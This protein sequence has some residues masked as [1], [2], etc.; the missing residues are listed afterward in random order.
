MRIVY[1]EIR[2][3]RRLAAVRMDLSADTTLLVGANNSGKTSAM[4]ALR[5]FLIEQEQ[6]KFSL[7]DVPLA[8]WKSIDELGEAGDHDGA[9]ASSQW[10]SLLPSLDVWL[11]VSEDEIHHI[12]HLIPT[13][14]WSPDELI[15]VRLHLEPK[16]PK[17]LMESYRQA[18][19]AAAEALQGRPAQPGKF[20][21][22]PRSFTDFLKRRMASVVKVNA[23]LLDPNKQGGPKDG[24]A[25]PQILPDDAEPLDSDPFTGLVRIDEVP[26][27]RGFSDYSAGSRDEDASDENEGRTKQLLAAQLRQYYGR[28]LDPSR[29]PSASDIEA[30]EAIQMAQDAFD[31]QLKESFANPLAELE[32]LGYPGVANPR[33]IISTSIK[34]LDGLNH[35]SA[36]QYDA[37]PQD[38]HEVSPHL[39]PEQCN[40]LGYQNLISM[41]FRLI[42]FRDA[43]MRVGKAALV[44]EQAGSPPAPLH[45]VLLEEPEAHLHVQVQQVFIRKA[46]EVLRHHR[47]LGDSNTFSTQLVVSTHSSHVAHEVEFANMRYFRRHPVRALGQT[48][49]STVVN[50]SEIFGPEPETARFVS[51]YLKATHADLFFADVAIFVEGAAERILLPYF[52]RTHYQTLRSCYISL[53]EVGGSHA[54]LL[55]NLI[56]SLGLTTL[57]ITDIDAVQHI[58]PRR[59]VT[60][61]RGEGQLTA[62][63]V[64]KDWFPQKE[65]LDY[66]LSLKEED[67]ARVY[68]SD[69]AVRVAYQTP[70]AVVQNSGELVPR[71]FEDAL[72]YENIDL[73]RKTTG[74]GLLKRVRE[75]VV[76]LTDIHAV[77]QRM[78]D[79]LQHAKKVELAL[80]LLYS[81]DPGKIKVPQYIGA[82]LEWL[83]S[84][85]VNQRKD[86]VIDGDCKE[87]NIAAEE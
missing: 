64:L 16:E 7:F 36:V 37:S 66:L 59:A 13:L 4:S 32:G 18:K 40:G 84:M 73:I 77:E 31:Q 62:N 85:S 25:Q 57:I 65:S 28:H 30:L 2:N 12:A 63:N 35:S 87:V 15:G 14:D 3:F 41:V 81:D 49:T 44:E 39:L 42:G 33:L 83:Q 68:K 22:W 6:K 70:I 27:Q 34:P 71:T 79:A 80:D 54:H 9:E 43:W 10:K 17:G 61:K 75:A 47:H 52:I 23:Y 76:D 58:T 19:K 26:A 45:L 21:L 11:A 51:R 60:P 69:F 72:V 24:P 50:L 53:L 5:Y 56:E 48:P 82:G 55:R 78:L 86:I 20:S 38:G 46:Y 67:K 1:V 8:L 74:S 29:S